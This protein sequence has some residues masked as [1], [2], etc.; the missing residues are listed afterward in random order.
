MGLFKGLYSERSRGQQLLL[1]LM[2]WMF[3]YFIF[4][5]LS[6][7]F[8]FLFTDIRNLENLNNIYSDPSYSSALRYFQL[9]LSIGIFVIPPLVFAY[10]ASDDPYRFLKIRHWPEPLLI[11]LGILIVF[12]ASPVM[13]AFLDL[14]QSIT[15]PE[16]LKGLEQTLREMEESTNSLIERMLSMDTPLDLLLNLAVIAVIPALGEE[17]LFRGGI[18]QLLHRWT[19]RPHLAIILAGILFSFIHFQFF[20]FLP[21]ML[22]G[23]LFGYLFYWSGN[24]WLPIL[25]HFFYNASQVMMVY[26]SDREIIET[27]VKQVEH[28]PLS[29][30]LPSAILLTLLL[31]VFYKL[32][33]RSRGMV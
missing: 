14:N 30:V 24:L 15:F 32:A 23:I 16:S 19:Q 22:L 5:V 8:M 3:F 12:A 25:A 4:N 13:Y 9:V 6:G 31:I 33:H 17:L 29:M 28:V 1:F 20:G 26:L 21:R 2:I 10:L 7:A 18:Q 27:N 11:I